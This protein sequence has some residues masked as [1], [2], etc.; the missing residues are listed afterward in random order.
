MEKSTGK[1]ALYF[2]KLVMEDITAGDAGV[3][4]GDGGFS[5]TNIKSGDFYAPGDARLPKAIGKVQ[6]RL[7]SSK[8]KRKKKKKDEDAEETMCPD[9][10]CGMPVDK[11]K[12][13]PDCPHC[14]CHKINNA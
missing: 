9:D 14:N 7:S 5:P 13:G 11:C 1:F 10:C 8:R 6:S 12:C 3:G 2:K 4:S